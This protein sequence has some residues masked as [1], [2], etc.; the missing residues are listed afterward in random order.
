MKKKIKVLE[1][2]FAV[3]A[4]A[5]Y[6]I[7]LTKNLVP[8]AMYQVIEDEEY[9]INEQIGMK[10]NASFSEVVNYW[11]SKLEEDQKEAYFSFFDIPNLLKHHKNGEDHVWHRYWTK[12]ALF[13]PML[14][15]QHI[16]MYDDE[17]TQDV[18]AITYVLDQT[19]QAKEQKYN[20]LLEQKNKELEAMLE[21]ER[22]YTGI[23]SALSKVYWQIY[24]VDLQEDTY[25]EVFNGWRM[26]NEH[27]CDQNKAQASFRNI[28]H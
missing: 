19:K 11:G 18:L 6:S 28:L 1:Q 9:S 24:S 20:E 21:V 2:A 25:I 12:T 23:M 13:E 5:Y 14:A 15:E 10:E 22:K 27:L 3:S 16:L 7:N 26:N 17:E 4:G 8:G